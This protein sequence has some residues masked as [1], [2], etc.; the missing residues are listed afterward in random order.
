MLR[1]DHARELAYDLCE[2]IMEHK[3]VDPQLNAPEI[4]RIFEAFHQQI[5][6]LCPIRY[7][8]SKIR[9]RWR[10]KFENGSRALVDLHDFR[11]AYR[12]DE[13]PYRSAETRV[14]SP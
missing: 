5:L 10:P 1:C 3:R 11:C 8:P 7:D 6:K 2:T 9:V 4:E 14:M 12:P 13:T